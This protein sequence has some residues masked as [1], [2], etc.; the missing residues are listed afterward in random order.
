MDDSFLPL[1]VITEH[2][3]SNAC[4]ETIL[5]F[6]LSCKTSKDICSQQAFLS[7]LSTK[8][9]V[10]VS[11]IKTFNDFV[12]YGSIMLGSSLAIKYHSACLCELSGIKFGNSK[13]IELA[14]KEIEGASFSG[15]LF[16]KKLSIAAAVEGNQV[17]KILQLVHDHKKQI[18]YA[19]IA[20][21]IC[22]N[23]NILFVLL[24][25]DL[26][27]KE[28]LHIALYAIKYHRNDIYLLLHD[29]LEYSYQV[30]MMIAVEYGNVPIMETLKAHLCHDAD[31]LLRIA[32]FNNQLEAVKYLY[33][34]YD[35]L[36]VP[37]VTSV[38]TI[39]VSH[40]LIKNKG[41][42]NYEKLF[43]GSLTPRALKRQ[44][45]F[46]RIKYSYDL[47]VTSACDKDTISKVVNKCLP[48]IESDLGIL[49]YLNELSPGILD[50]NKIGKNAR[51]VDIFMW[52]IENGFNDF[53]A[54][55]FSDNFH[56]FKICAEKIN[57]VNYL[58]AV[59]EIVEEEIYYETT[60]EDAR[61]IFLYLLD[62]GISSSLING[63]TTPEIF[64][65][66][67]QNKPEKKICAVEFLTKNDKP[68]KLLCYD[69]PT[70][71]DEILF[72]YTKG[73]YRKL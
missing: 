33:E 67:K 6:Y 31:F 52:A 3:V 19:I 53:L 12:E 34:N 49:K 54:C 35:D 66:V 65:H 57:S 17:E 60:N 25:K 51:S 4:F 15:A 29:R 16:R 26:T 21:L 42:H 50:F 69:Y 55:D 71:S 28:L 36:I 9:K 11:K 8:I 61:K 73:M 59:M 38:S 48:N 72:N 32:V 68:T 45:K 44:E 10:N 24:S 1:E 43:K 39:E 56:L 64:C 47:L 13:L 27:K 20:C 5:S 2:I 41:Y 7:L 30:S 14:Q 62:K 40:W 70:R 23:R 46:D 37:R 18:A 58:K 63:N 22:D